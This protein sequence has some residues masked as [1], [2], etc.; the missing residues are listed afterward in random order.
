MN[1]I[2]NQQAALDNALVPSEKRLKIERCNARIAFTKPQKE[3]TYQVKLKALKLSPCYLPFQITVEVPEI[4]MHQF[5]N[6]IK[7][8]GKSDAYDFKLDKKECRVDTEDML[9]TIRTG[10]MHQAWRTFDAVINKCIFGKTTGLDRLKESRAQI[11]GAMYNQMNVDYVALLWEDFMY[12][13][14]NIEINNT[15]ALPKIHQSRHHHF[16]SKDNTISMRNKINL[17]TIRDD[18]LLAYKTYLDY[19]TGKV[20]PKKAR[21]FKKPAS[22]KLKIVPVSPKVPNQKDTLNKSVSKKKAPAK[23]DRGKG[24]ELLFDAT[25]LEDAQLKETL[26]KSKCE[27]HKLQ[28]SGSS[29]EANFESEGDSE[30]ESNDVHDEDDGNGDDSGNDDDIANDDGG[31]NDAQDSE[32]TNSD[33]DENPSF[34][35][36]DYKEE[37]QDEEYVH[38]LEK[39][40]SN[41][42][43]KMYDEEDDDVT[44]E[45]ADQQNAS[46]EFGFVHEE[47]DAHV[48]LTTVHDKTKGP[49]KSSFVSSDFTSK[50]LNLDDS[51]LNINSLMDTSIVPLPPPPV[52]PSSHLTT[53]PQQQTPDSTTTK[54]NPTMTFPE[55][56]NFVQFAEVISLILSIIDN[57][58][59][60]NL[61]EEVN[62]AVRIQLNTLKEEAEAENQEF[63]DQVDSTMK[64]IIKEQT[65]YAIAA[66]LSEFELKK[67]LINKMEINE[68]INR[69]DIQRNLYNALVKS[70]NID[71]DIISTYSDVVT[72]KRGRD[73][74]DRDENPS[75]GSDR[76]KKRRKSRKDVKPSKGSKSKELKSS[77]SSKGTHS[78]PK[79]YGKSTQA[80]EPEFEAANIKIQQDQRNESSHIYDQPNNEAAPKHDWFQK[81][82][83][84]LT[85]DHAWNKS[86]SI[87]FRP[88]QKWIS[89]ISKECYKARQPPHM[90]DELMSAPI[91][92]IAYVMI[93]LKIDSLTQEILVSHAFNL[94]KGT[95]KSFAEL[96]YHFK[97]CYKAINDRLDWHNLEGHEYLFDLSK[98]LSLTKDRGHQVVPADYFINNDLEYLKDGSLNSRYVTSTTRTKAAKYDNI[99]GIKDIKYPHDVY[100]KR[101]IIAVTSVKVMRCYDYGYLDEIVVRRDDNVLY[102]FKEGDFPRLNLHLQLR[103]VSYQ[104]KLNITIPE[105][106]R[107][108]ISKLTQYT[109]YKNPQ[110]IIYQDKY[111]RNRL[112]CSNE[113]YKLCDGTL[114]SVRSVLNDIASNLEM[115]YLPKIHWSKLEMKRSHIMV[116]EIDK[117]L[118]ERRLMRNLEKFVGGRDY[119]NDLR[120]ILL[121]SV[122]VLRYEKRS[123]VRIREK[124]RMRWSQYW[125]KPN[126]ERECKLYDEF[127]KFSYK[128][129]ESLCEFYLR[130]SL[131]LNDINIYNMKLKQFQVNTKF[132]NTLPLE[133]SKFVTDVKLVWDL[134][135][136]NVDQLHAYLGQHE[137]HANEVRLMHEL[138]SDLRALVATHQMT[139]MDNHIILHSMKGDDPIDAINHMMSFLTA[140]DTSRYP[141]TN[142]QLRNSSNPRQ[143][144]T[145]N[146]GRV[147][148]Q[149]I[150]GR[151]TS[152]AADTSRT[153]TSGASR[154]NFEKQR[155]V[156]CYNCKGEGHIA[157]FFNMGIS[158]TQQW[159]HF[160]TSSG[161]VL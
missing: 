20:P 82:D 18:T 139:H 11:M 119:I 76:G 79:S 130:F 118:F 34:T 24:I 127:D 39:D 52:N 159:E 128:K 22:P 126:K 156:V 93:R 80:E 129:G 60:S 6:I 48:T 154:N 153:Y 57:Y 147:T 152:L 120:D 56:P 17:H 25:L 84:P 131:L 105:T 14:N 77:S 3:E 51:S 81:P 136:T 157:N 146:N 141:P 89:T 16:I 148:V 134:H 31:G 155:T 74:Q 45:L 23:A 100:S 41:N 73:D 30:Y 99:K 28:A 145:I 111:K 66:S 102:K 112:M 15:Y 59:A 53:I 103:G 143:Q 98:P 70:Y 38:T 92:F 67:I 121:D 26:R 37:E 43:E 108:N 149:P 75:V 140:V 161:K 58:L 91:D 116:K 113:L 106:T 158:L 114:S 12:Q 50:L 144:A 19:A 101:R 107:Y 133:W 44:K 122:E 104:K 88:P 94:L 35:L 69:S 36:K 115:D 46:P 2:A 125:N 117:L 47:E 142:N 160:F 40:K 21:K 85:P 42:E 72:L 27:T 54:T 29:E 90:F 124:C 95:C 61:K 4:Y 62:V 87:D 97:E 32:Q 9:S 10:Q 78:Q 86:K 13:A 8:I 83:K 151:H 5:W 33:D 71:K 109:A 49:L 150:Q 63:F 68:S 137:F 110:G 7:K 135:T 1:P 96:E 138:N 132:L 55:I 65:S 123:K 64:A